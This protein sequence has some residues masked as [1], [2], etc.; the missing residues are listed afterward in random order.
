VSASI[1]GFSWLVNIVYLVVLKYAGNSQE[2]KELEKRLRKKSNFN[3]KFLFALPIALW[4]ITFMSF[5]FGT[6][7]G[8]YLHISPYIF[9]SFP[10][11]FISN[12]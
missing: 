7:W 2:T 5:I 8:P 3:W 1:C 12:F 10:H 11:F 4:A 9:P 6:C